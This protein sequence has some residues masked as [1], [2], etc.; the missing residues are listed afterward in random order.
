[1]KTKLCPKCKEIK[2]L[3]LFGQNK[4]RKSGNAGWCKP[5]R[6][7]YGKLW[8]QQNKKVHI[9]RVAKNKRDVRD[10]VHNLKVGKTCSRCPEDHVA[11]LDFHHLA[12]K[13][14][15]IGGAYRHHS[16][17]SILKE[18]SNCILLCANCHRKEH[19]TAI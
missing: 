4:S 18:I 19:F 12:N 10:L 5:C 11:C 3:K 14:F 16:K 7:E 8:Y 2:A 6:A 15:N 9:K 13:R 17:A 1:M